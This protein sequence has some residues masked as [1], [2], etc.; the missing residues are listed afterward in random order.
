MQVLAR[1]GRVTVY[2]EVTLE[3]ARRGYFRIGHDSLGML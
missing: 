1:L 2:R 3:I